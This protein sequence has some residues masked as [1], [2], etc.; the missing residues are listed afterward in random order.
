MKTTGDKKQIVDVGTRTTAV[1][2]NLG[3]R[4]LNLLGYKVELSSFNT[5]EL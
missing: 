4:K 1:P 2:Y 3:I 5:H